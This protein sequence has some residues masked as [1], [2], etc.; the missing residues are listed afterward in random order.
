MQR[1]NYTREKWWTRGE[2]K[3]RASVLV[4]HRCAIYLENG[5]SLGGVKSVFSGPSDDAV[6]TLAVLA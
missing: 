4:S 2:S 6:M 3:T 1:A 5:L